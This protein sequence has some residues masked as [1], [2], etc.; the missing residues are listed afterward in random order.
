VLRV[1]LVSGSPLV[2]AGLR[3]AF[4][5]EGGFA[6]V[7]ASASID[8]VIEAM[9]EGIDVLVLDG[10]DADEVPFAPAPL[11]PALVRLADD[12]H[13]EEVREWLAASAS[14]LPRNASEAEIVAAAH[15]AHRGLVVAAPSLLAAALRSAE[16]GERDAIAGIDPLTEREREVLGRM[17]EGLGNRGIARALAISVH[18]AKFHV[19]QILGKLGAASRTEAVAKGFR[20]RLI[21]G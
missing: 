8:D 6:V 10:V 16:H 2:L 15:A 7:A 11:G 13:P 20:Q 3:S 12:P 19:G 18:T 17:A 4:A 14:V 9:P 5:G 21:P 1:A